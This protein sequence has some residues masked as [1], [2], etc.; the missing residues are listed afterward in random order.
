[1][2]GIMKISN[3]KTLDNLNSG[4]SLRGVVANVVD[5]DILL[6]EFELESRYYVHIRANNFRKGMNSLTLPCNGLN[7][8]SL[9]L[10]YPQWLICH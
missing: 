3:F 8:F 5:C 4:I 2:Y 6:S 7:Y 9:A 10:N 1:M